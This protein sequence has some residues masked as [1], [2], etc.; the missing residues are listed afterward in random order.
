MLQMEPDVRWGDHLKG[1]V[2]SSICL[3]LLILTGGHTEQ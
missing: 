3:R 2:M 1:Q